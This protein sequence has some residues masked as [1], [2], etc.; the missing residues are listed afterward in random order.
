MQQ[1]DSQGTTHPALPAPTIWPVTVAAGVA[2]LAF[3]AVTSGVFSA[4]GA[5]TLL[6]G[7]AGWIRELRH[8]ARA[9]QE[10]GEG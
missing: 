7:I 8:D 4:V 6:L 2:L 9:G 5:L 3:G 10:G 1:H